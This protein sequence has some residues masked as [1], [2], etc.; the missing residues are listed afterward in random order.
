MEN[1]NKDKPLEA[2]AKEDAEKKLTKQEITPFLLNMRLIYQHGVSHSK[3]KS[4]LDLFLAIHNSHYVVEQ[5]IRERAKDMTFS[6]ALHKIGFEEI[7]KKVNEKQPTQY[8]NRLLELNKIR[9]NAEHLNLIPSS[10][11]VEF[12]V[13]IVEDFL[14]WSCQNYFQKDY[15][16][17]KFE[18]LI[19][20]KEIREHMMKASEF[21]DAKDYK[22]ACEKMNTALAIFKTR[23]FTFFADPKLWNISVGAFPL[24]GILADLTLKIFFSNDIY[25]LKR[26][27]ALP[28]TYMVKDGQVIVAWNV[29]YAGFQTEE[30]TR[31]EYDAILNIILTYQDRFT[32]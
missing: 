24:T 3:N 5:V 4:R 17:L 12:Y 29:S 14:K 27:T 32:F 2:T 9:N 25:T 10:D 7:I 1:N 16:S 18:D 6:D 31:K 19:I 28:T 15:E 26:L 11:D 21:I 13:K 8:Y 20:D 30:E 23:F 22:S